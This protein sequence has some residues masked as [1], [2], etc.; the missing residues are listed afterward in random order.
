MIFLLRTSF[1]IIDVHNCSVL[2]A[3]KHLH[4]ESTAL[5]KFYKETGI[6]NIL[7]TVICLHYLTQQF[8]RW[9]Q[10]NTETIATHIHLDLAELLPLTWQQTLFERKSRGS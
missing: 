10:H 1:Q 5:H 7:T 2:K 3:Y 4:F 8:S 6:S 9:I